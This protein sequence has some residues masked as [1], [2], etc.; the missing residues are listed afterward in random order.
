MWPDIEEKL[1]LIPMTSVP[2]GPLKNKLEK[3]TFA[4]AEAFLR[5]T[6]GEIMAAAYAAVDAQVTA[7]VEKAEAKKEELKAEAQ[8]KID[9]KKAEL[10]AKMAIS[11]ENETENPLAFED[12]GASSPSSR[13]SMSMVGGSKGVMS[14]D[15]MEV[16][17]KRES[18]KK[19]TKKK[20][21]KKKG[22]KDK[23]EKDVM[24]DDGATSPV[25]SQAMPINLPALD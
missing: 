23:G 20:N 8:A 15:T 2:P 5:K 9:A 16:E 11:F 24:D 18:P 14:G 21:S 25:S 22:K 12:E 6:A 4:T 19:K 10:D 17:E 7:A 13:A 3:A 1:E